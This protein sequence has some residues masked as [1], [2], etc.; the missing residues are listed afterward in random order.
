MRKSRVMGPACL[1]LASVL[2]TPLG[3]TAESQ[4]YQQPSAEI[5]AVLDA[6]GLPS[7]SISPDQHTLA[8]A[9][10]RRY[11]QVAELARPILRLAGKRIDAAANGPQLTRL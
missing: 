7:H 6:K 8:I 10:L 9:E 11:R 1:A 3:H 4:I 2:S 5:R